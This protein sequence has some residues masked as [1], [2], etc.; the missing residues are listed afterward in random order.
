MEILS[1]LLLVVDPEALTVLVVTVGVDE[2]VLRSPAVI[3][4]VVGA[5]VVKGTPVV[6]V[7][8]AVREQRKCVQG[9]SQMPQPK[10][11]LRVTNNTINLVPGLG[12]HWLSYR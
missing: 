3:D 12:L 4:D 11:H 9:S 1:A 8:G 2:V 7:V 10:E 6:P 5:A